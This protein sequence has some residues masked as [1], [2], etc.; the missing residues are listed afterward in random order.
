[1]SSAVIVVQP[2]GLRI[3]TA[4]SELASF[5][6]WTRSDEFPDRGRIDYLDGEVDVDMSPEDLTT[7]G[8][9]KVAI[10]TALHNLVVDELDCG[11]VLSDRSRM[12]SEEAGLSSEPD[13]LVL[14][15][16]SLASGRVR[17]LPKSGHTAR[18]VELDG[19]PT[20][21]SSASATRPLART[22]CR[23]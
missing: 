20:W 11:E 16:A 2:E 21:S 14:L 7:H 12:S 15:E 5:R 9:V 1:M 22:G 3:P 17:L 18:W 8:S 10:S 19:P 4:V 13:V 23:C 6:S